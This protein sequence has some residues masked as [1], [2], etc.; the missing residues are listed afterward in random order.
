MPPGPTSSNDLILEQIREVLTERQRDQSEGLTL[1]SVMRSV[2]AHA[3]RDEKVHEALERRLREVE[4]ARARSE[5]PDL[6]TG[7][8][9]IPPYPQV[10]M[11]PTTINVDRKSKRPS[12]PP[13]LTPKSPV[14]QWVAMILLVAGSHLLARCGVVTPQP[15]PS[16]ST[17]T[18]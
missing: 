6:G 3:T 15:Q 12:L 11:P 4:E 5:G 16:S 2:D 17:T 10:V 9:Q 14:V 1:R 8:F 13:W 18:K 7:R